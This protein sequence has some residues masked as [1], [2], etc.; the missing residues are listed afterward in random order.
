[1]RERLVRDALTYLDTLATDAAGDVSLQR[2]L[3]AAYMR[4]GRVQGEL[5][6]ASMGNTEAALASYRKGVAILEHALRTDSTDADTRRALAESATDL[7]ALIWRTG[8][9]AGGLALTQRARA[10]LEPLIAAQPSDSALRLEVNRVYSQLGSLLLETGDLTEAL[11]V[12]QRAADLVDSAVARRPG[13]V[14]LRRDLAI[15]LQGVGDVETQL[16]GPAAALPAFRRSREISEILAAENGGSV[17]L[18]RLLSVALYWEGETLALMNRHAEALPLFQRSVGI[19]EALAAADTAMSR[20]DLDFGYLRVG[21]MLAR[22]GREPEALTYYRRTVES[23]RQ[24][25]AGDPDN[26]WT[27]LALLESTTRV[28]RTLAVQDPGAARAT[29]AEARDLAVGTSVDTTS[30]ADLGYMGGAFSELGD[31]YERLASA[32]RT[33]APERAQAQTAA[34][35]MHTRSHRIWSDLARRGVI[36]PVDTPRVA[37]ARAAV[38]RT[39]QLEV[40]ASVS[41]GRR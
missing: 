36:S 34:H 24:Q 33:S 30:A 8:D 10:V 3:A 32:P 31:A 40:A 2:E 28:C 25:V 19:G 27:R 39:A 15:A 18:Q 20:S 5:T 26:L 9:L 17:D 6:A 21:D 23:R 4:V 35:A 38:E 12:K 22:L 13:S 16:H 29:C 14:R 41:Q 11:A 1:V 7:A 37:L